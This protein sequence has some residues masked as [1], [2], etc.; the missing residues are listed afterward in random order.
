MAS[1]F[2]LLGG[3]L[4]AAGGAFLLFG[5]IGLVRMPDLYNRIQAGTKTTT[6]GTLLVLAGAACIEPGWGWKLLLIGLFLLFTNP[7]SSQVLAR[8]AHRNRVPLAASTKVD[9]LAEDHGRAP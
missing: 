8:A 9:R 7:L 1:L 5:G 3:L 6:L 2:D 4:M